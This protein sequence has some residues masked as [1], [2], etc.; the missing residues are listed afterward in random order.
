MRGRTGRTRVRC[1]GKRKA[2][3]EERGEV[4]NQ[5]KGE[6]VKLGFR[7][8]GEKREGEERQVRVPPVLIPPRGASLHL[9]PFI[10]ERPVRTFF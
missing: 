9:S 3:R 4:L 1:R 6:V 2:R 5:G 7:R 10:C 8:R